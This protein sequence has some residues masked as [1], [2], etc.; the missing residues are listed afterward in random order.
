M[1]FCFQEVFFIVSFAII[2]QSSVSRHLYNPRSPFAMLSD[3]YGFLMQLSYK[4]LFFLVAAL[5][6]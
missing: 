2:Y 4:I 1:E 6:L 5:L 3:M